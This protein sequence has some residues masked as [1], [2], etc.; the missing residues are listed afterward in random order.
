VKDYDVRVDRLGISGINAESIDSARDSI[1]KL[2]EAIASVTGARA[3][4]GAMQNKLVSTTNTL[5]IAKENL[6][7]ARS[8][9]AD[10]DIAEEATMMAQKQ[11]LRQAGVSVLAQANSAPHMALKLL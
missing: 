8:R 7:N 4:L 11:I 1:D 3:G 5:A 2:D 9:I 10:A 6:A